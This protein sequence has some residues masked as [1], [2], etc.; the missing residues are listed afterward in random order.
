MLVAKIIKKKIFFPM[1]IIKKKM[2]VLKFIWE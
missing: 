2:I 1:V